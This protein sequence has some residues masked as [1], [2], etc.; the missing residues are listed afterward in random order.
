MPKPAVIG[1]IVAAVVIMA[2]AVVVLLPKGPQVKSCLNDYSWEEIAQISKLI[3]KKGDQNGAIEIAKKY[4]LCTADGKK[5]RRNP[6]QGRHALRRNTDQ[7]Y[8][9]G[10]Q[11]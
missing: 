2:I 1:G 7:G 9:H 4:H 11:P 5:A 6:D 8:D 10:I 3:S